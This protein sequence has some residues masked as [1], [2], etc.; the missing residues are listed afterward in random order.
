MKTSPATFA[1]QLKRLRAYEEDIKWVGSRTL[2]QAWNESENAAFMFWL[3]SKTVERKV[4]V[5]A[6]CEIAEQAFAGY[7]PRAAIETAR[8]WARGE[9]TVDDALAAADATS[10]AASAAYAVKEGASSIVVADT[11]A[12]RHPQVRV[13]DILRKYVT[14]EMIAAE[15]ERGPAEGGRK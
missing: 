12:R 1:D 5:L 2:T 4:I 6:V 8:K 7:D 11:V 10:A 3:A 9:A 13:L 14:A 15:L